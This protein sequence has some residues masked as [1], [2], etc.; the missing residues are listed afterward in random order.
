M[1]TLHTVTYF[2]FYIIHLQVPYGRKKTPLV[3]I[4]NPWGTEKGEWKG[5]WSDGSQEWQQVNSKSVDKY[6][7]FCSVVSLICCNSMVKNI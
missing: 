6:V 5:A 2:D 3:R 7:C 4:R 1:I